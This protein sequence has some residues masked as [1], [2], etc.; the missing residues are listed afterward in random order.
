MSISFKSLETILE[1]HPPSPEH[2]ISALQDVQAR[3]HYLPKEAMT[4]VCDHLGVPVSRGWAVATFYKSFSL[5]P[6]G[7]HGI[8][9]CMGTACHVRGARNLYDKFR[10]DLGLPGEEGTTRDRKF[11]L[12]QVR[13]LG[14]CSMGPVA[15]VD[16]EIH[17]NLNQRKAGQL[18]KLYRKR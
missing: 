18:I 3:F 7:E 13:C 16:E 10:R 4:A 2:L 15:Q 11:T 8:S 9:V 17:G 14:C 6:Q 1:R 5:E 12:R